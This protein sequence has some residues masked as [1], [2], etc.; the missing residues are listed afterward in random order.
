MRGVLNLARMIATA[1]TSGQ[2]L[3][4]RYSCCVDILPSRLALSAQCPPFKQYGEVTIVGTRT[5]KNVAIF[6]TY[7]DWRMQVGEAYEEGLNIF[8]NQ[9]T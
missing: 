4:F 2:Y 3:C 6:T 9:S 7:P 5:G 8:P 1:Q